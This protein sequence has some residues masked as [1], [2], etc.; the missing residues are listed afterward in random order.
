[1]SHGTK[2]KLTCEQTKLRNSHHTN[3]RTWSKLLWS[4][5][6]RT[7]YDL[8]YFTSTPYAEMFLYDFFICNFFSLYVGDLD[9]RKNCQINT[10]YIILL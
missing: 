7:R 8:N 9:F 10:F 1:M 5:F 6:K 2:A 3:W 4:A